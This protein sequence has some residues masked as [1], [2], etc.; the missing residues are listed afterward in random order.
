MTREQPQ[1]GGPRCKPTV[2]ETAAHRQT[3]A[4]GLGAAHGRRDRTISGE[5]PAQ[6]VPRSHARTCTCQVMQRLKK[7]L[8]SGK[9]F[10]DASVAV[11]NDV[12]PVGRDN[13]RD[14]SGDSH[15]PRKSNR[16]VYLGFSR[17]EVAERLKAAVC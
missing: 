8:S 5:C 13:L 2:L 7:P 4:R 10:D 15:D 1:A 12:L 3:G 16:V 9:R 11:L 17:G 14:K 6:F